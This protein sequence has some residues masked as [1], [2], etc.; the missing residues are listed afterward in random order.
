MNITDELPTPLRWYVF[1][2]SNIQR[3]DEHAPDGYSDLHAVADAV[4]L[5][6]DR[7]DPAPHGARDRDHLVGCCIATM[8]AVLSS[9]LQSSPSAHAE[10]WDFIYRTNS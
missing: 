9:P 4:R 7:G 5:L 3:D 6:A 2:G 1:D 10:A 8:A